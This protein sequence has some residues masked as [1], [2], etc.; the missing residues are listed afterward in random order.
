MKKIEQDILNEKIDKLNKIQNKH[1]FFYNED[2][3]SIYPY[4]LRA[5][6]KNDYILSISIFKTERELFHHICG[7]IKG[8][9]LY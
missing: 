4:E 6:N 3:N 7:I 1:V 9:E 8:I 2:E 5:K